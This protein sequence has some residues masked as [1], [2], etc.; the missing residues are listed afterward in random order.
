MLPAPE[1]RTTAVPQ[2][3]V[4]VPLQV[5]PSTQMYILVPAEGAAA[6]PDIEKGPSLLEQVFGPYDTPLNLTFIIVV[7]PLQAAS[8]VVVSSSNAVP[9][10]RM[11][12]PVSPDQQVPLLPPS[13]ELV[14]VMVVL[15][16][17]QPEFVTL[18]YV[19]LSV[20]WWF[21]NH[22]LDV[23]EFMFTKFPLVP[24][25]VSTPP[26]AVV[27]VV[28]AVKFTVLLLVAIVKLL[29]VVVPTTVA[30]VVV[31]KT[32]VP[33]LCPKPVVVAGVLVKFPPIVR[34][35]EVEVNAADAATRKLPVIVTAGL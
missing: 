3:L 2:E 10:M 20:P 31:F 32:T 19:T 18:A 5:A 34:L 7:D 21:I 23:V 29:N 12:A 4:L 22:W 30:V 24:V 33:E 27:N 28:P 25:M 13:V 15:A 8:L 9:V 14:V 11:V 17:L 26:L 1:Y 16:P 35:P 6:G